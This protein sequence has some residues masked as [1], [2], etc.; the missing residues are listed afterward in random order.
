MPINSPIAD[1]IRMRHM[2]D[3]ARQALDF[4]RGRSR[5]D[6]DGDAMFRRAVTH[7]IQEIGEAAANVSEPTRAAVPAIPW[8][9]VVGMRHNLVHAYFNI[10]HEAVWQVLSHELQ[11]LIDAIEACLALPAPPGGSEPGE[12]P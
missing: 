3:A 6:L 11:P 12:H 5:S 8:R 1:R 4:V 2:L 9:Q 7:C 10:K